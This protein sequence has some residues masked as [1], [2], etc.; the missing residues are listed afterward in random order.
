[1][2]EVNLREEGQ[3]RRKAEFLRQVL[4]HYTAERQPKNVE[5]EYVTPV[6][7]PA[8]V[9]PKRE[10]RNDDDDAETID[11]KELDPTPLSRDKQYCIRKEGTTLMIGNS[12]V[13][14]DKPGVITVKEKQFK[15]TREL[16]D[17]LAHNDVDKGTISHNDM[18]RYKS[19]L[20]LTSVLLSGYE[21]DGTLKSFEV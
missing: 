16:W 2:C 13:D 17:L 10:S 6:E 14:L 21:P 9:N 15:L 18:K 4:P 12:A 7:I 3:V 5:Q 8:A 19:I 11:L 20:K 1:M